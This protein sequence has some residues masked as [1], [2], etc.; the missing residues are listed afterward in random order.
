MIYFITVNGGLIIYSLFHLFRYLIFIKK[1]KMNNELENNNYNLIIVIPCLEE[2]NTITE[3][4]KYFKTQLTNDIPIILVTSSKEKKK[5]TTKEIIE[6]KILNKYSNVYLCHYPSK[7]GY[8]ADQLN[9]VIKH[10]NLYLPLNYLAEQTYFCVYNADSRPNKKTFKELAFLISNNNYPFI[11]QQYSYAFSNFEQLSFLLKGFALY[12]SNFELKMGLL[13]SYYNSLLLHKHVVSHGFFIRLD[14]LE[15]IDGFNNQYWCEDIYM[16]AIINNYNIKIIPLLNIEN[17]ETPDKFL[18]L[19]KQNGV[20]FSTAFKALNIYKDIFKKH[21]KIS[22]KGL[23]G[24]I[25][26]LRS[27]LNWLLFPFVLIINF[28]ISILL[29]IQYLILAIISYSIYI[30]ISSLTTIKLVNKLD[31]Q[32][33]KYNIII[34]ISNFIATILSN[35]GPLYYIFLRP[36]EKYKTER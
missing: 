27:A 26:E 8:M 18:K 31:N 30:L 32:N 13:N 19:I 28:I 1:V 5:P 17:M 16:S 15:K 24:M 33:Y 3:T 29:G 4:I 11:L 36:K 6:T 21:K 14:L 2:Q 10:L 22:F 23:L 25:N 20:W 9:Y 35:I 34:F 12:Q 7:K